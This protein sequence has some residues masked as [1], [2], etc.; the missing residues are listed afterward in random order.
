MKNLVLRWLSWGFCRS[1]GHLRPSPKKAQLSRHRPHRPQRLGKVPADSFEKS[2]GVQSCKS[3]KVEAPW[4]HCF[5]VQDW[6]TDNAE[7]SSKLD[8]ETPTL[9]LFKTWTMQRY[10]QRH[11]GMNYLWFWP[12]FLFRIEDIISKK[13]KKQ[14]LFT[15]GYETTQSFQRFSAVPTR[16]LGKTEP[17]SGW[18]SAQTKSDL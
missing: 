5:V 16:N 11:V 9:Q 18:K 12:D 15:R 10:N 2:R 17:K 8:Q 14:R 7:N 4:N 6:E 1:P 3:Q 13:N